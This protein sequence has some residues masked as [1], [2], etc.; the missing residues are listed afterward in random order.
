MTQKLTVVVGMC[1]R[2]RKKHPCGSDTWKV[3]RA[4]ADI[5]VLCAGC[6]RKAMFEREE[7]ERRV[8]QIIPNLDTTVME[9]PT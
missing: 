1:V 9:D 7:F 5:G 3:T 8:R 6:G 4:G 2:L